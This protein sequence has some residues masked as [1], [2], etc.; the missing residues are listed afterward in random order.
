MPE[1]EFLTMGLASEHLDVPAPTLRLWT[2]QLEE[3]EVHYVVRNDKGERLYY[4]NDLEIFKYIRDMKKEHGRKTTTKDLA[5]TIYRKA[6]EDGEFQIRKLEDAPRPE[7]TN[8]HLDLLNQ[9][10]IKQLLESDRIRQFVQVI[11]EETTKNVRDEMIKEFASAKEELAVAGRELDRKIEELDSKLEQREK[12]N[13]E[14]MQQMMRE[15]K[16][17]KEESQPKGFF[18]KIFGH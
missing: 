3:N 13:R 5:Y 4:D 6:V 2:E 10:D 9:K 1:V 17:Q 12:Q 18:A 11:M 7:P 14:F 8:T 16:A 15:M